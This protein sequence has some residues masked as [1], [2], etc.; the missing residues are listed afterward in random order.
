MLWHKI[1]GAGG[2]GGAWNVDRA[3]F[4]GEP[5]H[6]IYSRQSGPTGLFI[7]S[8]GLKMYNIGTSGDNVYE[9][10]LSTAWEVGTASYVQ[11]FSV[12]AQD[13]QPEDVFFKPDGTKMYV[14]G[15]VGDDVIEYNLSTAWDISTASYVQNF[16]VTTQETLPTSVFFSTDGTEMYVLGD[17]G[18]DINQ[19][20]LSTAWDISTASYTRAQSISTWETAPTGLFFSS[21]GLNVFVT[22][23][24]GVDVNQWSLSTAWDISTM[25]FVRVKSVSAEET[26]PE[27]VFFKSDGTEMYIL[28]NTQDM[29]YQYDLSTA[30][31]ISTASFSYP[32]TDFLL[33]ASQDGA[34]TGLFFKP[35]GTKLYVIGQTNDSVY[36]YDLSSAWELNTASYVQSFSVA[37]QDPFP[38]DVFFKTDGTKMYAIGTNSNSVHEY[39]L[40][41]AWDV[42]TASFAQ[43]FSVGAV[44]P[45]GLFFKSDGTKMYVIGSNG[46]SVKEYNLSTAWDISTASYVQLFS[47]AA[48]ELA[49][50]GVS[51]KDDGTR[52]YVVG[53]L[54]DSVFQY[55]LS[56][57]WDVS[58]AS[59]SKEVSVA[60]LNNAPNGIFFKSDGTKM[61]IIDSTSDAIWAYTL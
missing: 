36:E 10:D 56:T 14:L 45:Q 17:S 8:D 42:S 30:W 50:T 5:K 13:T 38:S 11:L 23:T 24:A 18:N 51:F 40:S 1:Q 41:T 7:S 15:G 37:T 9:F 46:D 60:A 2:V 44:A 43:S 4:E 12:A 29:V 3:S 58:T 47:I 32:T 21:D 27:A 39:S 61:Y 16:V 53:T 55:E 54:S 52:M 22:G 34:P 31:D 57:A 48:Q 20:S 6:F 49:P 19:Y 28:G 33:V 35:D 59:Y 25:S 26:L